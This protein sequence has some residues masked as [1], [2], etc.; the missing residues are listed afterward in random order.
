MPMKLARPIK[1][2]LYKMYSNVCVGKHLSEVF[3]IQNGL[4]EMLYGHYFITYQ[5]HVR[6]CHLEGPRK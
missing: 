4:K 6:I 1:M 3:P 5:L 2:C